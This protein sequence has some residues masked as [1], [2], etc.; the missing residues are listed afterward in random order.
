MTTSA[1]GFVEWICRGYKQKSSAL[2]DLLDNADDATVKAS[3]VTNSKWIATKDRIMSPD[4]VTINPMPVVCI[5]NG[6]DA[7]KPITHCLSFAQSDKKNT[8]QIGENGV[9]LKQ[10]VVYLANSGLVISRYN[11]P[12]ADGKG[13]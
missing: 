7:I 2:F 10:S 12:Q 13:R 6:G 8:E 5:T 3:S 4:R 1:S 9:G 11:K